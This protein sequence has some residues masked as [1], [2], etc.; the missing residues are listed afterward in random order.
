MALY[1]VQ[2]VYIVGMVAGLLP[3]TSMS[4]PFISYGLMPTLFNTFIMGFVLSL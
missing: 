3:L 2:F 1:L 4:L